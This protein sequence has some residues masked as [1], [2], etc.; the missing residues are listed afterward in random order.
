MPQVYA[1]AAKPAP[2][3][4]PAAAKKPAI[5]V[6]KAPSKAEVEKLGKEIDE[7]AAKAPAAK[8][9]ANNNK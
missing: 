8:P 1:A 4:K 3:A 9:E 7:L 2:A 6:E 5:V